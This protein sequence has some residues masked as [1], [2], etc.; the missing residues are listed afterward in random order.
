[1]NNVN[2]IQAIDLLQ[3]IGSSLVQIE[4]LSK[5]N[6]DISDA[7]ISKLC[8]MDRA[9]DRMKDSIKRGEG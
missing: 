7:T 3:T 8:E 9:L 4:D 5:D 1:M 6:R 2:N